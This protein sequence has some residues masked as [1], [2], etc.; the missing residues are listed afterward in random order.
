M[1]GT[2]SDLFQYFFVKDKEVN[3]LAA[4]SKDGNVN[5]FKYKISKRI[6]CSRKKRWI[7]FFLTKYASPTE[8]T[9]NKIIKNYLVSR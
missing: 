8:S 6:V 4:I 1:K 7:V 3:L 2:S 9:S 5:I